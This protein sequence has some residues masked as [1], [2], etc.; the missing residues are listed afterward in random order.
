ML[1]GT[2]ER[3]NHGGTALIRFCYCCCFVLRKDWGGG[4]SVKSK[5]RGPNIE[6]DRYMFILSCINPLS[7]PLSF[8]LILSLSLSLS[9]SPTHTYTD[10]HQART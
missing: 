6:R 1:Q 8:S 9:L 5:E 4:G 3:Q 10:M 2:R 7:Y